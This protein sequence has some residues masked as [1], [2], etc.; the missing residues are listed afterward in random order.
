MPDAKILSASFFSFITLLGKSFHLSMFEK[1][2]EFSVA[3][4]KIF[5]TTYL[6]N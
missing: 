3:R 6:Q 2:N 5:S 1:L 4:N